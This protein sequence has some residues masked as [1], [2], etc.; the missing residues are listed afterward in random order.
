MKQNACVL[1]HFISS[2]FIFMK[3]EASGLVVRVG[4]VRGA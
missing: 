4:E 3:N 1:N 2:V